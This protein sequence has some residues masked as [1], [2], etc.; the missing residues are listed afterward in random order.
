M[1]E[2]G[3]AADLAALSAAG[4]VVATHSE[5]VVAALGD[6]ASDAG[7]NLLG[8]AVDVAKTITSN[9]SAEQLNQKLAGRG[10][11]ELSPPDPPS[12]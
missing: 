4:G 5:S 1:G 8:G 10:S 9:V 3:N 7:T 12:Q 6:K 2:K 11:E